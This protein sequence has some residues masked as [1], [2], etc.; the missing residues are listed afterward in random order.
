[1]EDQW[2]A[3]RKELK[4]MLLMDTIFFFLWAVEF[5]WILIREKCPP[6]G[7][8]GWYVGDQLA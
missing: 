2:R 6:G 1:L 3:A 4:W 7:F 8:N 5:I